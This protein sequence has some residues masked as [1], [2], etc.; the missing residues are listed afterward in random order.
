MWLLFN[1]LF[2]N[3]WKSAW[4]LTKQTNSKKNS[5]TLWCNFNICVIHLCSYWLAIPVCAMELLCASRS[6]MLLSCCRYSIGLRLKQENSKIRQFS[7]MIL[8]FAK[9]SSSLVPV[10]FGTETG[11]IITVR[12][13]HPG[14]VY[15]KYPG[16][17]NFVCKLIS[18]I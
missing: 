1:N 8:I 15:C 7:F 16:S 12:P 4:I 3:V 10:Q 9:L 18:Q 6:S 14:Q 13:T 5:F 2:Q 11:L 17:W